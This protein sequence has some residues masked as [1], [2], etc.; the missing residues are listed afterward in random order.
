[1]RSSDAGV[2]VGADGVAVD[3]DGVD[4]LGAD[5]PDVRD[6]TRPVS[7]PL[8]RLDEWT[9]GFRRRH[10]GLLVTSMASS[11]DDA[12]RWLLA[13]VDGER[14]LVSVPAWLTGA[15]DVDR[16]AGRPASP[17]PD[18]Y[19]GPLFGVLMVRR[20]GYAAA[21]F[22]GGT[23]L[24]AKVGKRHIHGRTAA[25]GWSQQ[26]YARRRGHQADEIVGAAAHAFA[27]IAGPDAEALAV[28]VTGG[29]RQLLGAARESL[30]ENSR[31]GRVLAGLPEVHLGIGT[32][33]PQVLA[34][35]PDR[36]LALSVLLADGSIPESEGADR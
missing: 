21:V 18:A 26:R 35:V 14:A 4:G 1:M 8:R 19:A 15:V 29:D 2:A 36:V 28:L 20:A 11:E 22:A 30:G 12:P 32:P 25:G 33:T 31:V 16:L 9:A 6:L 10:G 7:V 5:G 23:K 27:N 13:G 24:A 34:G 17:R 3:A